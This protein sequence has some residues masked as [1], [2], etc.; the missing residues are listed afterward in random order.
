[1]SFILLLGYR[2]GGG[3]TMADEHGW[4]LRIGCYCIRWSQ[5]PV[6]S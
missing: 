6:E 2:A 4:G 1:M 5:F 3:Y